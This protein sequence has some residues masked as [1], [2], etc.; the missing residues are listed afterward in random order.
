MP[1]RDSTA[2]LVHSG[3]RLRSAEPDPV[4]ELAPSIR[5]PSSHHR[6]ALLRLAAPRPVRLRG[7]TVRNGAIVSAGAVVS[8]DLAPF[9]TV[10]GAPATFL[11]WRGGHDQSTTGGAPT[12]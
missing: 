7:V 1:A 4:A 8:D 11:R 12:P 3:D 2:P 10:T 6:D 9:S 5:L